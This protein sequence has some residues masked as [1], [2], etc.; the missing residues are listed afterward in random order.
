MP[1]VSSGPYWTATEAQFFRYTAANPG[2]D[3]GQAWPGGG[4]FDDGI[5]ATL[6][7][8]SSAEGAVAEYLRRHPELF[9]LE[10]LVEL[11]EIGIDVSAQAL[12]VREEA[13]QITVG[14]SRDRLTSSDESELKRY[15]ECRELMAN[16]ASA[17]LSGILYPSASL[18]AFGPWNLVL[19][20]SDGW[21]SSVLG[22]VPVPVLEERDVVALA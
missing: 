21:I 10:L 18:R 17:A 5:E 2:F 7:L 16:V 11:W 20:G 6:Y 8:A 15:R 22:H 4:R 12:D 14:I 3:P 13:G 19:R 1:D 9:G